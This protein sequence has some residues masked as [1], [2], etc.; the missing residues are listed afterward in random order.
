[1][2]VLSQNAEEE[3][4]LVRMCGVEYTLYREDI[5]TRDDHYHPSFLVNSLAKKAA[6]IDKPVPI[7]PMDLI[8]EMKYSPV[9]KSDSGL[10][11]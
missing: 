3:R 8:L 10:D 2:G 7:Q 5:F 1:M 6:A 11:N 4:R 9:N